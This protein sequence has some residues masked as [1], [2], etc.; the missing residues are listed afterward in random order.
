MPL[1]REHQPQQCSWDG[2]NKLE[3]SCA[4]QDFWVAGGGSASF[5]DASGACA[6]LRAEDASGATAPASEAFA[7]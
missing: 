6:L 5:E 7:T 2:C 1:G 3:V 4:E